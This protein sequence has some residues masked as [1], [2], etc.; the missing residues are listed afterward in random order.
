VL[1]DTFEESDKL[2]LVQGVDASGLPGFSTAIDRA[3][4]L[5]VGPV[6]LAAG[7]SHTLRFW[8]LAAQ[9]EAQAAARLR[10]LRDEPI[11][12]PGP[13]ARFEIEP[14]FPN[15]LRTGSGRVMNFPYSVPESARDDGLALVFEVYDV[16]GRRLVRQSQVL[17]PGGALPRITWDGLLADGLEAASGAY[18]YV[19][20]LGD[21]NRSGRLVLVH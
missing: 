9:S 17:M 13:D 4:L 19:L 1:W 18:L 10:E 11:E 15:P 3:A 14:P 2:D 7:E 12:P 21:E 5:S 16:A 8:L 6:D 20:R